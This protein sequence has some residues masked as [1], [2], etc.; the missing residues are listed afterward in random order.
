M[1]LDD[2]V[3]EG[4]AHNLTIV[5]NQVPTGRCARRSRARCSDWTPGAPIGCPHDVMLMGAYEP[6]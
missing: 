6:A 5:F 1:S 3:L 4:A 2:W